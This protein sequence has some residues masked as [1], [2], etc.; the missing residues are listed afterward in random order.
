MLIQYYL[1]WC[2]CCIR[3]ACFRFA[4][5]TSLCLRSPPWSG[6]W[7]HV[8]QART[9]RRSS[10]PEIRNLIKNK[11]IWVWRSLVR[12]DK[13]FW[14]GSNSQ[15]NLVMVF[16]ALSLL[17]EILLMQLLTTLAITG[18]NLLL[19]KSSMVCGQS[20]K[21]FTLVNYDSRVVPDKK[22]PHI[23]TLES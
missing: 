16:H 20:Y 2:T 7:A 6:G 13:G 4:C 18:L 5:S 10:R 21:H 22:I 3:C 17:L 19:L 1:R 23:T 14:Y 12:G 9:I 15:T 11:L 8:V